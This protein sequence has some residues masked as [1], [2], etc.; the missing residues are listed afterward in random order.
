MSKPV[1]LIAEELS[2][3]TV[4]ALGPDFEIRNV[5]GTDRPALLAALSDA[6][7]VLVRSATKI[8]AEAIAAAPVLKVVARAGVGL[9]N[10]DIKAATTAGVMV[11]NAPTSN[12]ISAAELTVGHILSLAR[13]IPA[14]HASLAAGAWKRSSYTGVE[15]YE[16]T[17]G[18]IGLGRI[19]ALITQRLQAFGVTVIAYDPYVT[20]ARAQQ[21]GVELVSLEDLLRR[22]DFTTI[23]MPRTPETLG[24]ISD[25]QFALMKPTA[26][27]VNVAR[28][29][30]IDEDALHRALTSNTIAGAGL[31][32]FVAEPPKDSP[33]LA[34]PNVVVTPHLGASTDEAQEKAGVSV[35]KSVRLALGGELVP[36]AV[37]VAGGVIDPYVRPGI[38]LVEK[39][40]QVFTA[41]A[42]SPVTS[43]DVEVHGELAEYD[44][45]VLK[46]A[47]LKG[48]FT[49]VVSDQVSYVN[50]PLIAEQRGV[51]V[52]LI[53]ETDSPEYRNVLTI[54]G[55]QSD[56]PAISVSG[57]LTG[58]KQVEKLVEINGHDVEVPLDRHHV[59]MEYTDRPGIVAVYGKEFGQAGINIAAMQ[60]SREAAG[61]QALSV[62]TVDSPVPA[63]I[64]E[65]VRSAIDA[66][67]LREIDITL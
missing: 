24:M 42:T 58:P 19:G 55:A 56:G 7:A 21:L 44:V 10:V 46:L 29:G 22:A 4:D 16:K 60:I 28:G 14:A 49:D 53:T 67:S 25:A 27:V 30:L 39:L 37:N 32:V 5:D 57:T 66:S 33:L 1:V 59:V 15:L 8:D 62:L 54:R 52:R 23:H 63:E 61:G 48:V 6:H 12:I 47:A 11:V 38:P 13:H 3:A 2:P 65:H 17:V 36:D 31:D 35:A 40:G 41:L 34:L 64:L 9:D 51:T 50:A 20:T 26:F 18:I 43:I 45:S